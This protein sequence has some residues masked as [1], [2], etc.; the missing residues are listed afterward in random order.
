MKTILKSLSVQKVIGQL[1]LLIYLL[2]ISSS[3]GN[4][5][6]PPVAFFVLRITYKTT[7]GQDLLNQA[8][9]NSFLTS[10]GR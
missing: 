10:T 7:N 3:C 9:S 4:S 8:M 6:Q 1:S 2:S 5:P